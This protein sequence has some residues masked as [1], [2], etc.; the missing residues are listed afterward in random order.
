ME[1]KN[2]FFKIISSEINDENSSY[3][4]EIDNKHDVFNGHFPGN[5]VTPGVAQLEIIKELVSDA[6]GNKCDLKELA[7]CKF[8]KVIN[9]EIDAQVTIDLKQISK[10]NDELKISAVIHNDNGVFL[11]SSATYRL[12]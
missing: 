7:N 11:K 8:L 12:I 9:P 3:L 5:P 2:N 4:I 6:T 10:D 1:F